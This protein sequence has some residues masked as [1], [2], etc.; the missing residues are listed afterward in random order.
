MREKMEF[1]HTEEDG[2]EASYEHGSP[3]SLFHEDTPWE[4]RHLW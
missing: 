2:V 4:S 3:C 1:T